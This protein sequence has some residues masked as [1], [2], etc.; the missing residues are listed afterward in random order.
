MPQAVAGL[1]KAGLLDSSLSSRKSLSFPL[2]FVIENANHLLQMTT[3]KAP[4]A[5]NIRPYREALIAGGGMLLAAWFCIWWIYAQARTMQMREAGSD[6]GDLARVAATLVDGD[7]HRTLN[8]P[9][10]MNGETHK[11]LLAPLLKLHQA[12]PDISYIYT[13]REENGALHIILDTTTSAGELHLMRPPTPSTIMDRYDDP[14]PAM[15]LALHDGRVHSS[16]K[17]Y[18]DEFGVFMSGYAPFFDS[19]GK[20]AGVAGVDIAVNELDSRM[21]NLRLGAVSAAVVALVFSAFFGAF[22][23]RSRFRDLAY[24]QLEA[25][26]QAELKRINQ[27]LTEQNA[28]QQETEKKLRLQ[29][30]ESRKLALV[31]SHTGHAVT[32][33]DAE[34]RV[35]WVNEG[36]SR[37]TGYTPDEVRGKKPGDVLQGADTDPKTV[38][39]M[40]EQLQKGEGF[41]VEILNYSK[42]G[43]RTWIALEVQPIRDDQGKIRN[44][45]GVKVDVTHRKMGEHRLSVYNTISKIFAA[46]EHLDDGLQKMLETIC[47]SE[48]WPVGAI[49]TVDRAT[50]SLRCAEVWSSPAI[51]V[52]DYLDTNLKTLLTQGAGLAGRV[53][54]ESEAVWL[55]DIAELPDFPN[56]SDAGAGGLRSAFGF[57]I[58]INGRF[59]GVMEFMAGQIPEPDGNLLHMFES[60]GRQCSQFIIRKQAEAALLETNT[61]Q[62]AILDSASVS[63]I[64]TDENGLVR[65][66]NAAARK[67]LGYEPEQVVGKRNIEV[68]HD[69]NELAQMAVEV[70]RE[71]GREIQP[72]FELFASLATRKPVDE[73]E[74][75]YIHRNGKRFPVLLSITALK[76][77][78]GDIT[79]FLV[80]GADITHRKKSEDELRT[81]LAEVERFNRLMFTRELRVIELK[82]EINRLRKQLGEAPAYPS[83]EKEI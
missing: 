48:Q 47:E 28:T 13:V 15:V 10:Q 64:S 1:C 2:R 41:S 80:I 43:A 12:L 65:S 51:S 46:A 71:L 45:M 49:W 11:K 33:T 78:N 14:D 81:S 56:A 34:G 74:W 30:A 52:R 75:T 39:Y 25:Q 68:F 22:L 21:R 57:P 73:R 66:F 8:S 63:I 9:S 26:A 77:A 72:G 18:R 35:E 37:M 3:D 7:L 36:F 69:R 83:V 42:A 76:T 44:Y 40:H 19:Q 82:D 24:K 62:K 70:S 58:R 67:L 59:W 4:A 79:G 32:L 55:P 6:L 23:V 54:A 31:A 5:T 60:V 16:N 20:I 17:P 50:N 27:Q 61:L 53:W 38:Q 29:E